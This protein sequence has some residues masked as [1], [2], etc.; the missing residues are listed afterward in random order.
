MS[1]ET[2]VLHLLLP[3]TDCKFVVVRGGVVGRVYA[4]KVSMG[5]APGSNGTTAVE[6][7][8]RRKRVR[9]VQ[10]L[11]TRQSTDVP[12]EGQLHHFRRIPDLSMP[13]SSRPN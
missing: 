8:T 7:R 10:D 11:P 5:T 12:V 9:P 13:K 1:R 4:V 2:P 6:R 3:L